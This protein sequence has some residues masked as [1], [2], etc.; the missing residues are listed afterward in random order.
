[1]D[2]ENSLQ[3]IE[4]PNKKNTDFKIWNKIPV[5]RRD[6]DLMCRYGHDNL[7]IDD[8]NILIFGGLTSNSKEKAVLFK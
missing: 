2:I 5:A 6:K 1:L 4:D 7:L 3:F 8:A